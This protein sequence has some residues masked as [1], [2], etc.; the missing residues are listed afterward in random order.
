MSGQASQRDVVFTAFMLAVR[1]AAAGIPAPVRAP[2]LAES[3]PTSVAVAVDEWFG[4]RARAEQVVAEANAMLDTGTDRVV[5]DDEAG[6]GELAFEL[7]WRDRST[8]ILV[9]GEHQ[10]D[11]TPASMRVAVDRNGAGRPVKPEDLGF[12]EDLVVG[13]VASGCERAGRRA[14]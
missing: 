4:L 6:T 3:G 1:D 2:R 9:L 11:G 10:A 8:R 7:R 14:D 12:L 5:L 13:M